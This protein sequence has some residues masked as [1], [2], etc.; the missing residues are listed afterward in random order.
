MCRFKRIK[1][2]VVIIYDLRRQYYSKEDWLKLADANTLRTSVLAFVYSSAENG[3]PVLL[4]S[5]HI[6]YVDTQHNNASH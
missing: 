2:T 4:S 1:T 3:V 6:N 5:K